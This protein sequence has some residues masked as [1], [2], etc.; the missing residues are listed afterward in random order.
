MSKFAPFLLTLCAALFLCSCEGDSQTANAGEPQT[1]RTEQYTLSLPAGY[2]AE[3]QADSSLLF[4]ADD[5]VVGGLS[6]LPWENAKALGFQDPKDLTDDN[7]DPLLA[8]LLN[9]GET[10]RAY[11]FSSS[12]FG[13]IF[14]DLSTD[15]RHESHSFFLQDDAVYDLWFQSG[16]LDEDTETAIL[17]SFSLPA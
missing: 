8:A 6:C 3:P 1:I 5:T 11:T 4:L 9:E 12:L 17:H 16:R 13:D 14:L 7:T 15:Q 10:T 2:T